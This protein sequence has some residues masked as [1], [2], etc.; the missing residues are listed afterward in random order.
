VVDVTFTEAGTLGLRLS[1]NAQTG[2]I[3]VLHVNP[4]T[5]AEHHPE[6][7]A[8]LALQSV[9]GVSVAG[10]DYEEVLGM[11]SVIGPRR[12]LAMGFAG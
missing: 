12:P 1:A 5:Q 3:E 10:K 4:G 6:L 8:G 9:G 7:R 2:K 11:I